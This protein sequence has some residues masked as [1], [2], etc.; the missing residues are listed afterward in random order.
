MQLM[1][2]KLSYGVITPAGLNNSGGGATHLAG[3]QRPASSG[4]RTTAPNRPPSC[5]NRICLPLSAS[6]L[7]LRRDM[8]D[9]D[10][11]LLTP[12]QLEEIREAFKVR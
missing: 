6:Q 3:W 11:E 1:A 4:R 5:A 8:A 2:L 12:D 9:L 10:P 7:F